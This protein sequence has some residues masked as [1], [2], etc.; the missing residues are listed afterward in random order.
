VPE[1]GENLAVI[2]PAGKQRTRRVQVFAALSGAE[3]GGEAVHHGNN[4]RQAHAQ[5]SLQLELGRKWRQ[6][7][8]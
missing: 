2:P 5:F 7:S 1:D 3:W 4:L 8:F 6:L